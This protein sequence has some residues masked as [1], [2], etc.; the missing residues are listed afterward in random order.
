M[1]GSQ[2]VKF[3]HCAKRV[4]LNDLDYGK[5]PILES[6][7]AVTKRGLQRSVVVR[8]VFPQTVACYIPKSVKVPRGKL[9]GKYL[10]KK[11]IES[12]YS[13]PC[14]DVSYSLEIQDGGKQDACN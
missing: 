2:C 11:L 14:I 3:H 8:S 5:Y 1:E 9:A 4:S 13:R 6:V 10:E 7:L 12:A